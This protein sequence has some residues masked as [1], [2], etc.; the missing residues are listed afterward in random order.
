MTIN[1]YQQAA[2]KTAIYPEK[3]KIILPALGVTGEAGE[4]SDKVK[5]VIR[6][7]DGKFD[8]T[9]CMDIAMEIGDVLWYCAALANDIGFT[10]DVVAQ[11]NIKKL[12]GRKERGTLH[13]K[14]EI[15]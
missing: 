7:N 9:K 1:E 12:T 3:Y 6:D 15:R 13:G 14:G 5:K 8:A 4:C 11:M 10:L 2:L